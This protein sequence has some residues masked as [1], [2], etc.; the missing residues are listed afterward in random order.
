[1]GSPRRIVCAVVAT[2]A[3]VTVR[4]QTLGAPVPVEPTDEEQLVI[5]QLN[6]ASRDQPPY[7]QSS[8]GASR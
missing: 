5:R 7:G 8:R 2:G 3:T 1:M 6:H 4:G